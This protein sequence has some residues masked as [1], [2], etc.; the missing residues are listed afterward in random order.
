MADLTA[1]P[2]EKRVEA[3]I[4]NV[5]LAL[6]KLEEAKASLDSRALRLVE[7][8]RLYV[9]DARYYL[10][11]GDVFTA[12]ADIAYAEGLVDALR[13]LG[14]AR[15]EWRPTSRLLER[16]KVLVAG[17]FDIIHPGHVELLRQAW[18]RGRAYVVVARDSSVR[19]FKN[20]D[21]IVPEEQRLAVVSAIRYV[22]KAVLGSE[23]DILEPIRAIRPDII[24]LGPDQ[25]AS[26]EW[27]GKQLEKEGL[28]PRIERLREKKNCNLC[29]TTRIACRAARIVELNNLCEG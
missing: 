4:V 20:R 29:S 19:R 6:E 28:S 17:T 26:E 1:V 2:P 3:Y 16:P 23:E 24:L 27:L 7:L 10:E 12:L 13:W 5:E 11:R 8:A 9:S 22:D 15:L 25:W 18:L 14:L 21:P